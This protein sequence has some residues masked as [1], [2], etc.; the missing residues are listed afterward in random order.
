MM[1]LGAGWPM[2]GL[3]GG[4][5][6]SDAGTAGAAGVAI[7]GRGRTGDD[8]G[9]A[10]G[11]AVTEAVGG[12]AISTGGGTTVADVPATSRWINSFT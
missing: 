11:A 9:E 10:A 5:E 6:A 3:G 7:V 4:A 2:I 1:G 12:G 8:D